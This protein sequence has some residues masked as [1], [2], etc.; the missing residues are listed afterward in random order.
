MFYSLG[1]YHLARLSSAEMALKQLGWRLVVIEVAEVDPERPW[2]KSASDLE[3]YTLCKA[4]ESPGELVKKEVRNRL[5][6]RLGELKPAACFIPGWGHFTAHEMLTWSRRQGVPA[7]VMSESKFDDKPRSWWREWSKRL[8]YVRHFDAA[9]VGGVK[10]ASYLER[11][12]MNRDRIF[13]GYDVVDNEFFSSAADVARKNEEVTR[14]AHKRIPAEPYFLTANRFIPR[15]NLLRLLHSYSQYRG[16]VEMPWALVLAGAGEQEEEIVAAV[17]R[18]GLEDHVYLPGFVPSIQMPAYYAYAGAFV[19]PALTEQ[20]GLVVNEAC[21]CSLPVLIS[22]SVG[23]AELVSGG[24][25][26]YVFDPLSDDEITAAMTQVTDLSEPERLQ[27]GKNSWR[28]VQQFSPQ[29][30]GQGLVGILA[31]LAAEGKLTIKSE[32]DSSQQ[33]VV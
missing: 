8:M 15:K 21:A 14:A 5:V 26:G 22:K 23:A 27:M 19:H 12:G 10:H 1:A 20:W 2:G 6:D 33:T 4:D 28:K 7:I 25:N 9:L 30:F 13:F 17:E 11:L 24:E 32:G 31:M 29:A 3:I 16:L 18:L